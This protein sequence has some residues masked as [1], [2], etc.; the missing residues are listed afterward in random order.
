VIYI[1]IQDKGSKNGMSSNWQDN[2]PMSQ[3]IRTKKA[4]N[5]EDFRTLI[6]SIS[7]TRVS[8]KVIGTWTDDLECECIDQITDIALDI[9]F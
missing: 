5:N 8:P 3:L 6:E 9:E 4:F 2:R 7:K 1:C